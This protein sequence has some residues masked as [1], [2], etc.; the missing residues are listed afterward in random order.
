M[1][2]KTWVLVADAAKARLFER[3]GKEAS[4]TEIACY[5][6][7]NGRTPGNH[8]IHGRLPRAQESMD[9][10]RHAIEPRTTLKDKHAKEFADALS[11]VV[12]HGRLQERYD[13]LVLIAPPRFLGALHACM[14]EQT[15]KRAVSEVGNDLLTLSPAELRGHLPA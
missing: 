11:D 5:T 13:D 1:S 12:Q 3:T 14:D 6:H 10:S 9:A 7:P 4:L 2:R 8:P 15:R